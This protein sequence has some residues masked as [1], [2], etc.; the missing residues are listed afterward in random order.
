V[1]TVGQPGEVAQS[2]LLAGGEGV[3]MIVHHYTCVGD[4]E[5]RTE[6]V[7]RLLST[8]MSDTVGANQNH[9]KTWRVQ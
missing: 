2:F 6:A 3:H 9:W 1:A 8:L 5:I 7:Q 4:E